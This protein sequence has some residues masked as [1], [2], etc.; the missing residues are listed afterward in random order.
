MKAKRKRE[1][2]SVVLA[3]DVGSYSI[4]TVS[5]AVQMAASMKTHLRGVFVE[6]EDLLQVAGLPF[7]REISL[8][9][10][11]ERPT[12]VEK[13]QRA[14][15][16]VGQ[17]FRQ[18]LQQQAQARK[19]DWSFDYR[20]GRLRDIGLHPDVDAPCVIL[21]HA[22]RPLA[23]G[24]RHAPRRILLITTPSP[25]QKRALKVALKLFRQESI[26]VTLTGA[27]PTG[28]LST[29]IEGLRLRLKSQVRLIGLERSDLLDLLA[30][31]GRSFDCAIVPQGEKPEDLLRILKTLGCPV[32]LTA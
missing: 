7:T 22:G 15:R 25:H 30:R 24:S 17:R 18:T 23:S 14:L 32:I 4:S 20:R 19:I 6:D 2:Q 10:A 1:R 16:S 21:G 26:E 3:A 12:S 29:E 9:T 27:A 28:D 13:M 5:L 11:L 8:T 31:E